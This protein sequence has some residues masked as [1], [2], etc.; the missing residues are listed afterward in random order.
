MKTSSNEEKVITT[1]CHDH[2]A[3]AC[4]LKL[5]VKD[6]IITR[7]ET[8]DGQEPQYRACVRGR[9]YRQYVYNANRLKFPLRRAGERG[10]GKFERISWDDALE[11][12]ASQIR[13]VKETYGA[14]AIIL[15]CSGGDLG[16]LHNG[17]LIDRVLVETGGYTGVL[18]TVSDEG[19]WFATMAD[20][21]NYI[22][23]R[24]SLRKSRLVILWGFNPVV[25]RHYMDL[26]SL[27]QLRENGVRFISIDPKYTETAAL[28]D[29]QWIPVIPGT[30][31]AMLIAMA[32]VIITEN[33]Q[34]QAFLDKYTVGFEQFKGYVLGQE[35][36]IAKTPAWAEQITGVLAST[37]AGLAR[38]YATTK[39][40]ALIDSFAPGRTAYGEQFTR[41]VDTLA[42]MTGNTDIKNGSAGLYV[43]MRRSLSL[44]AFVGLRM[45]GGENP[46]HRAA[47]L[48]KDSIFYQRAPRTVDSVRSALYYAGGPTTAYLNRV[49][50]ADAILKGRK[51]GYPADYKLLYMVTINWLNQYAN[52][53]KIAQALRKLEFVVAQEQFITPTAKYADIVLPT[54]TIVERNDVTKSYGEGFYGYMNKA[55]D[56]IGE[57]RSQFEIAVGLAAKLGISDFSNKTEEGWL[58]E[59]VGECNDIP[60]Y[61]TFKKEGIRKVKPTMSSVN[62][63]TPSGKI[64]IYSQDLADMG[65]P[66][67]PPIPKYIETWE[68]PNDPLAKKYPLQLITTH[69]WRRTHS[70]FDDISWLRELETQAVLINSA[71]AQVRRIRDGDMVRVF[72]DRGQMIIPAR[73]TE[74][75][76]PGVVDIPEG[77]GYDPDENG[78]D[79]GGC[80]NV[81]TK[82]EPSPG[83]A[84]ASNTSLVQVERT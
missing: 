3:S 35:D 73:V 70:K 19:T 31:V 60:D 4:L 53:N 62:F 12:I 57:S 47:P 76:M 38:Q 2:C 7:I 23:P 40:A 77:A 69:Y 32:H 21:G 41:A 33:L 84:F 50:V 28:L 75:I 11:T 13:R 24:P 66:M 65:N 17:S 27:A 51:G 79:R 49:R 59:I 48:R 68:S 34:D 42:A 29:A 74:R 54:C 39:P 72:N 44:G 37:I 64:E 82:D 46:V 43:N 36:H 18:G 61:D 16:V 45:K 9:A 56:S 71:D 63:A 1:V 55:I 15:L 22:R 52:T 14:S 6:G 67:L 81:L 26:Q 80:A 83:G 5:H 58:K 8:D 78:I 30:D 10:E 25:T 20:Y